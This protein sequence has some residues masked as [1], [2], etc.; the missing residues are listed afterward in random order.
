VETGRGARKCPRVP[1]FLDVR[2]DLDSGARLKGKIIDLSTEGI[3]AKFETPMAVTEKVTVEFLLPNTLNSIEVAG[4]VVWHRLDPD[5]KDEDEDLHYVGIKFVNLEN[6]HRNL[7]CGYSLKM[8]HNEDLVLQQG[9]DRVLSDIR[10]LPPM[11]RQRALDI[12]VKK[13]LVSVEEKPDLG[14]L[15]R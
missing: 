13:G 9:V 3:S 5:G 11:E 1:V 7:I 10:N 8:L 2:C 6:T 4:E 12:L 14:L 15:G